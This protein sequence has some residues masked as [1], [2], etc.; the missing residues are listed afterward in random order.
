MKNA[1][2]FLVFLV[3]GYLF[4]YFRSIIQEEYQRLEAVKYNHDSFWKGIDLKYTCRN[5]PV[6]WTL[7]ENSS[8]E[9]LIEV[10]CVDEAIWQGD[11]YL[12]DW[13]FKRFIFP[14]PDYIA[15]ACLS[16]MSYYL[17]QNSLVPDQKGIETMRTIGCSE[18]AR[19]FSE[20]MRQKDG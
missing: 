2:K 18:E 19:Y 9:L 1:L 5:Q 17:E 15:F 13:L 16:N 6:N 12:V 4:F 14:C 11:C 8:R 3:A 20:I 7:I 10:K